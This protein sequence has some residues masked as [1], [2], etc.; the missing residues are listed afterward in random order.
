MVDR[1]E[2]IK[3]VLIV[4]LK[5]RVKRYKEYQQKV[6]EDE[7]GFFAPYVKTSITN[8]E[9]E[10]CK[11]ESG[12][13]SDYCYSE[14]NVKKTEKLLFDVY[15]R[16]ACKVEDENKEDKMIMT[17][18]LRIKLGNEGYELMKEYFSIKAAILCLVTEIKKE[19][20]PETETLLKRFN[21]IKRFWE[22]TVLI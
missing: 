2:E 1:F 5:E 12:I 11:L 7:G 17:D 8:F 22:K 20:R 9:K 6:I 16:K 18:E 10:V 3:R 4:F 21:S 14:R 19:R 15:F 13:S